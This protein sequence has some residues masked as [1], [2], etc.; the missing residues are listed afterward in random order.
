MKISL[1]TVCYNAEKTVENTLRSVLS[2]DYPDIEYIVIDGASKDGTLEILERY[3]DRFAHLVSARDKGIYDAMNKGLALA[4]GEVVGLLNADDLFAHSGV[5]SQI[6]AVMQAESLDAVYGD[7]TY[8]DS[9]APDKVLRYYSSASFKPSRMRWGFVP[10]HPTLYVRRALYQT[11]GNFRIDYKI[12]GDYE[13][14]ARIFKGATLRYRY[15][16]EVLVRMHI[17]G[18][19]T[20]TLWSML[21][22][23]REVIRACREN[24]IYTNW[25]MIL[26]KYPF[27]LLGLM[28]K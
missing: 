19:S 9:A 24:N 14:I 18:A 22:Q 4:T 21:V 28:F 25:A 23:N 3:R 1:I 6:A 13:F 15:L 26:C 7:V 11:F 12:A 5:I 17:G 20:H 10:A 8:F 27:K 16:P 2:Q